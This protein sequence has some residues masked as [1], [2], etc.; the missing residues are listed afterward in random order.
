V[1]EGA[2]PDHAARGGRLLAGEHREE[3][4]LAGAVAAHESDLVAGIERQGRTA[5]DDA[6]PSD[7]DAQLCDLKHVGG[8]RARARETCA[9]ALPS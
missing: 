5:H 7:L 6:P 9:R 3:A 1:P 4:R 8:P 2:A